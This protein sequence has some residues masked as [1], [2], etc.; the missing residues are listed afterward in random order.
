MRQNATTGRAGAFGASSEGHRMAALFRNGN[1]EQFMTSHAHPPA[2]DGI[3]AQRH[4]FGDVR[5]ILRAAG[6]SG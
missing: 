2:M 1:G 6:S 4:P 3:T 5:R